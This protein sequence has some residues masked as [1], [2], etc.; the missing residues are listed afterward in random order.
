MANKSH[1]VPISVQIAVGTT[2]YLVWLI[3]NFLLDDKKEIEDFPVLIK[4]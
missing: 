1:L 4:F 3:Y 2:H